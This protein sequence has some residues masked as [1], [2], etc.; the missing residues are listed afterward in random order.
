[1]KEGKGKLDWDAGFLKKKGLSENDE[2]GEKRLTT[3][4]VPSPDRTNAKKK[5]PKKKNYGPPLKERQDGIS[6]PEQLLG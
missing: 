3:D 5:E 4:G 1:V 2:E 6:I